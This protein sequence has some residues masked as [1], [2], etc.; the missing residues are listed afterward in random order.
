VAK[1]VTDLLA[2]SDISANSEI[3]VLISQ[4]FAS[5]IKAEAKNALF[6][7]LSAVKIDPSA[8]RPLWAGQLNGWAEKYEFKAMPVDKEEAKP[9]AGDTPID[10]AAG[11][12]EIK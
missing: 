4:F 7:E 3:S 5:K 1:L 9:E 2:E 10:E 6:S 11:R 12:A 8:P